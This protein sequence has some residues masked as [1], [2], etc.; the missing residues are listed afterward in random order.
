MLGNEIVDNRVMNTRGA[1]MVAGSFVAPY[2]ATSIY[3]DNDESGVIVQ[4][5]VASWASYGALKLHGGSFNQILRNI[6]VDGGDHEI[7]VAPNQPMQGNTFS[8]NV[9]GTTGANLTPA[10]YF[11]LPLIGNTSEYAGI[12][13]SGG[14]FYNLLTGDPNP[15]FSPG[16]NFSDWTALGFDTDSGLGVGDLSTR[17]DGLV[18]GLEEGF[19]SSLPRGPSPT[20]LTGLRHFASSLPD[21]PAKTCLT[22][23]LGPQLSPEP[24]DALAVYRCLAALPD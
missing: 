6:L 14:N 5:N 21:A 13:A 9:I 15:P 23:T 19:L 11:W 10:N 16:L 3:L 20:L 12:F 1:A 24:A 22:D 17:A 8:L 4:G 7:E 18:S 2:G